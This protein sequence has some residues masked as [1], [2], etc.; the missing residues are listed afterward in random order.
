M[1]AVIVLESRFIG[2]AKDQLQLKF[3]HVATR[4]RKQGLGRALFQKVVER[5]RELGAN[6]LYISAA[7]TENAVDFYLHV[8][9]QVTREIEAELL[10]LEPDD[11]HMEYAIP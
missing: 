7:P 4:H 9:C 3:M 5:A 6:R 1:V 2:R 11:I 10:E 8:G